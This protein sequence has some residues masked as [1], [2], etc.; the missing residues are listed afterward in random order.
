[1][2]PRSNGVPCPCVYRAFVVDD[3]ADWADALAL[4]L[5]GRCG[6]AVESFSAPREA[7]QRL[8]RG[9]MPQVILVDY[10]MPEIDG[11]AFCRSAV[12]VAPG[13]PIV[14]VTAS[15][16]VDDETRSLCSAVLSKPVDLE[17]LYAAV[18]GAVTD[19]RAPVVLL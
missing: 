2:T 18:R 12:R 10:H 16:A 13:I 5:A 1:M 11:A 3:D 4:V 15:P 17:A 14:L 6:F 7:L 19:E 8:S 9:P